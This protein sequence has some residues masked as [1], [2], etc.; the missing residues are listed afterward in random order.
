MKRTPARFRQID[1]KCAQSVRP[2]EH[3]RFSFPWPCPCT[4]NGHKSIFIMNMR[5]RGV[6]WRGVRALLLPLNIA[7]ALITPTRM[8]THSLTPSPAGGP[9][10]PA[11]YIQTHV[12]PPTQAPCPMDTD[13]TGT[14]RASIDMHHAHALCLSVARPGLLCWHACIH[15]GKRCVTGVSGT[16]TERTK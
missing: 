10:C 2:N 7:S 3:T 13:H 8:L 5:R 9:N 4:T 11:A 1:R 6:A 12:Q 15:A 16:R 14:L